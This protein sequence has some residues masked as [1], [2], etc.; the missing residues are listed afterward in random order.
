[1]SEFV[2][3]GHVSIWDDLVEIRIETESYVVPVPSVQR[4][5]HSGSDEVIY[6][7]VPQTTL[8]DEGSAIEHAQVAGTI[9]LS[10]THRSV[11]VRPNPGWRLFLINAEAFRD[12]MR[13]I[14]PRATVSEIINHKS[15]SRQLSFA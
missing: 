9:T 12:V 7:H 5:L 10:R 8:G 11:T 3:I 1:M 15:K 6:Q 13:G 2:T 14:L 4:V